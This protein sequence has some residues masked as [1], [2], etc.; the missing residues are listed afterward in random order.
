[1]TLSIL[2]FIVIACFIRGHSA[3]SALEITFRPCLLW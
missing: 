3:P 1:V 2:A